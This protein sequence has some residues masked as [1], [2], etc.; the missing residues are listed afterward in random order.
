M[1]NNNNINKSQQ[2]NSVS[3]KTRRHHS[4]ESKKNTPPF[5]L[6]PPG[7]D[8]S[9]NF[10]THNE[11][12]N[13]NNWNKKIKFMQKKNYQEDENNNINNN[14]NN[15]NNINEFGQNK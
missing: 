14:N 12:K 3:T 15:N 2:I 4:Q 8:E 10:T 7:I 6:S 11:N 5:P 1:I 9:V 13:N